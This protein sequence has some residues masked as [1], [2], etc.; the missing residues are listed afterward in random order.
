MSGL[1][2]RD[3]AALHRQVAALSKGHLKLKISGGVLIA[4]V[5]AS[6]VLSGLMDGDIASKGLWLFGLTIG[7]YAVVHYS[8]LLRLKSAITSTT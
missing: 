5:S 7:L 1:F 4:I 8:V 3:G 6:H 2:S